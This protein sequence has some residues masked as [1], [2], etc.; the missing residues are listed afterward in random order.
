MERE[1]QQKRGMGGGS[2]STDARNNCSI[3]RANRRYLKWTRA[4]HC[5]MQGTSCG[6]IKGMKE[7]RTEGG[8]GV[9]QAVPASD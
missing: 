5:C 8:T 9:L 1:A 2:N 4:P 7:R 6:G 3:A